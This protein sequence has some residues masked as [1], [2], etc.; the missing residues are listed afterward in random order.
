[1]KLRW[2]FRLSNNIADARRIKGN[3]EKQ[4]KSMRF[5]VRSIICSLLSL[6][7]SGLIFLFLQSL[8]SNNFIL[9]IGGILF[10][11]VLGAGGTIALLYHAIKNWALQLYIN[12]R[13][14]G[15]VAL[16]I[17]IISLI[18]CI[19]IVLYTLQVFS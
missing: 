9:I 10:G 5:G 7:F 18:G 13:P 2:L 4:S 1:M 16:S 6:P 3:A 14:I 19:G 17:S 12:K 11:L 8:S 15:W